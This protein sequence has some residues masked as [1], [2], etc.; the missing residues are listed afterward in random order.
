[1]SDPLA[2]STLAASVLTQ[3]F[4]F[5]YDRLGTL[6]DAWAERRAAKAEEAV[7]LPDALGGRS[8]DLV[9]DAAV[10]QEHLPDLAYLRGVL[11]AYDREPQRI[12]ARD[13]EFLASLERL[14]DLLE[15]VYGCRLTFTGEA[16]EPTGTAIRVRQE[17]GRVSGT[18]TG[19]KATT[20]GTADVDVSQSATQ[21]E[22]GASVT[23][24]DVDRIG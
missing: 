19:V 24:V 6:L 3:G 16:R 8:Q 17:L 22:Q 5:L 1:M 7:A 9:S 11:L 21:V 13:P 18:G 23:G 2:L 20:I 12:E 10:T 14:R 4:A 15:Q